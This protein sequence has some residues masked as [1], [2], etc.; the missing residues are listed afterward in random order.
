[1]GG[2]QSTAGVPG[3]V[4]VMGCTAAARGRS[5]SGAGRTRPSRSVQH[6]EPLH[7]QENGTRCRGGLLH[8]MAHVAGRRRWGR[9]TYRMYALGRSPASPAPAR[10]RK[11]SS[12]Y[13]CHFFLDRGEFIG[14][15]TQLYTAMAG[16]GNGW[17]P[18]GSVTRI[19]EGF[20]LIS[21]PIV[22]I[23]ILESEASRASR[24]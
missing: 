23:T 22:P 18:G 7:P 16:C 6:I 12:Q 11:L 8:D 3:L 15:G 17:R 10:G 24:R 21:H 4:I 9:G 13:F 19:G 14:H 20:S 1:M 2:F 5:C